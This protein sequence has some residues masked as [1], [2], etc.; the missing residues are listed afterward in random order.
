MLADHSLD[1]HREMKRLL[2]ELEK[3]KADDMNCDIKLA[4]IMNDGNNI[5][6]QT[7]ANNTNMRES[8]GQLNLLSY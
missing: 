4:E 2:S 1:E 7:N 6:T 8:N 3:M 5:Q